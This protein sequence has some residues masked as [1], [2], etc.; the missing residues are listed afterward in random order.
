MYVSLDHLLRNT[1]FLILDTSTGVSAE[2]YNQL[3][4]LGEALGVPEEPL[5][6]GG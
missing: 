4:E 6:K 1:F 5:P 2:N 3:S